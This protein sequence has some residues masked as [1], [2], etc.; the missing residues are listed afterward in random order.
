MASLKL[1]A[2]GNVSAITEEA[3]TGVVTDGEDTSKLALVAA[4]TG[5]AQPPSTIHC[6]NRE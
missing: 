2:F 6:D 1:P 5:A 3:S 4:G